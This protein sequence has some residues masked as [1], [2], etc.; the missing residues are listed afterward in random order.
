[1]SK[2]KVL[3]RKIEEE[4][5]TK[6]Q[7]LEVELKKE[8][9]KEL[10]VIFQSSG[11]FISEISSKKVKT[12]DIKAVVRMAKLISDNG[13]VPYGFC[14]EDG[15]G[16]QKGPFYYIILLAFFN[17]TKRFLIRANLESLRAICSVMN[18]LSL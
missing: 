3:K 11:S 8:K 4:K 13:S 15:N 9:A 7:K 5:A 17:G 1:M 12:K 16:K 6:L 10:Y 18:G 14:F 2:I